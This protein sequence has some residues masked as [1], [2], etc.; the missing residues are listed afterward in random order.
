MFSYFKKH[1]DEMQVVP[2]LHSCGYCVMSVDSENKLKIHITTV[3]LE[4]ANAL[5]P[6]KQKN[7]L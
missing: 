5:L 2:N 7:L 4:V 6:T 1:C 3:H